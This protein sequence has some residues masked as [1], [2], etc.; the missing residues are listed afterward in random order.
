M[1]VFISMKPKILILLP[2]FIINKVAF[3]GVF[4]LASKASAISCTFITVYFSV[5]LSSLTRG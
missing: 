3:L 2:D 4:T 5:R 1:I